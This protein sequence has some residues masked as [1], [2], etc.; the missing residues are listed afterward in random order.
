[1]QLNLGPVYFDY[2]ATTPVL[3]EVEQAM[4]P[5]W[6][7]NFGNPSSGHSYGQRAKLSVEKARNSVAKLLG[8]PSSTIVFTSGATESIHSALAGWTMAQ[9]SAGHK[10]CHIITTSIEHKATYGACQLSQKLG[11]R[12]SI[13]DCDPQG[14]VN[15]EQLLKLLVTGEPTLF[16]FIHGNN[17][18]GTIQN[19]AQ[20]SD[21][22]KKHSF[23][24]HV[25]AAQSVG[26]TPVAIEQ[27]SVD[28]LSVS[29]HKIYGPKGVGA[30]YIR[31]A[32]NFESLFS[33][34]GQEMNLRAGTHNVPSIVGMGRACEWFLTHGAAEA[35][36]LQQLQNRLRKQL[37]PVMALV[38]ING[39]LQSRL[40]NNLNISLKKHTL[41]DLETELENIAFSSGS[42]CNSG[43]D[44]GQDGPPAS[45]VL[46]AIGVDSSVA[47]NTLRIGLG[48]YT[49]EAEVD[50]F[51]QSLIKVLKKG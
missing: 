39:P 43:S 44:S 20:I 24:V 50:H 16:S 17:E 9:K 41:L 21:L 7:K 40:P 25:D 32:K 22:A 38:Q 13:V 26:K 47:G 4:M 30:L 45:H 34:G 31:D 36:R 12:F 8:V 37:E 11:A 33:G 18:I 6:Q 1:M 35:Q 49:T 10:S 29:G 27:L 51:S 48:L 23:A 5:F 14:F 46:K 28:F 2:H 42:A 15:L 19:L 3:P